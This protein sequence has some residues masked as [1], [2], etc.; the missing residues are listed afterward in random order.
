MKTQAKRCTR[1]ELAYLSHWRRKGFMLTINDQIPLSTLTPPSLATR[2]PVLD[3]ML[4]G[5]IIVGVLAAF[6]FWLAKAAKII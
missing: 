4:G 3:A 2:R 6:G 5:V 1:K